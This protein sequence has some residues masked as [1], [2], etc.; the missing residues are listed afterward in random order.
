MKDFSDKVRLLSF[1]V[2]N[3]HDVGNLEDR[4]VIYT[5][6]IDAICQDVTSL[7]RDVTDVEFFLRNS[8]STEIKKYV[9]LIDIGAIMLFPEYMRKL[10]PDSDYVEYALY[11]NKLS[12]IYSWIPFEDKNNSPSKAI[13]DENLINSVYEE[14]NGKLWQNINKEDFKEM[15]V[16]GDI[17]FQ[18]K[19]GNKQRVIALLNRIS[20]TI[21]DENTK[22]AWV[23]NVE[24]TLKKRLSQIY[25]LDETNSE[26]NKKFNSFLNGIY[27]K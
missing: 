26:P 5:S 1:N 4:K 16:S 23:A 6:W 8:L 20:F 21:D 9:E 3:F 27:S 17:G 13:I 7:M 11:C 15:L 2:E 22:S 19:N 25:D 12:D 10:M 24:K 18:I 14:C